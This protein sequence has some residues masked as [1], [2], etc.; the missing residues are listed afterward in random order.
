MELSVLFLSLAICEVDSTTRDVGRQVAIIGVFEAEGKC[1][2]PAPR[3]SRD[4]DPATHLLWGHGAS[5]LH[6]SR[7][8]DPGGG[9]LSGAQGRATDRIVKVAIFGYNA[10]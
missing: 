6:S 8:R 9:R 7:V 10:R 1:G 4:C 3:S 5:A 2:S